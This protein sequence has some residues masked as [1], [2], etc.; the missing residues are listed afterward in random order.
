[1]ASFAA[2][3]STAVLREEAEIEV[4]SFRVGGG[5]AFLIYRRSDGVFATALTHERDRWKLIS[6]TP[7]PID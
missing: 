7:N 5:Y 6:A 3:A 1:M 2:D 4:L